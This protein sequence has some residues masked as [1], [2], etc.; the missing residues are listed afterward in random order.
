M[1]ELVIIPAFAG[2]RNPAA[3]SFLDKLQAFH[4]LDTNCPAN[5]HRGTISNDGLPSGVTFSLHRD[6]VLA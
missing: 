6:L 4:S 1:R 2:W 3:D 5:G